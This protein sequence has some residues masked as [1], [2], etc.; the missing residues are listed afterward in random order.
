MYFCFTLRRRDSK[1]LPKNLFDAAK[2][3]RSESKARFNQALEWK[4]NL[5]AIAIIHIRAYILYVCARMLVLCTNVTCASRKL[6]NSCGNIFEKNATFWGENFV[7]SLMASIELW[8]I[9]PKCRAIFR[10][11]FEKFA[12]R[13]W[14]R[15]RI[16]GLEF[17]VFTRDLISKL[18][19]DPRNPAGRYCDSRI[20]R[21]LCRR[22]R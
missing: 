8:K 5:I 7:I 10:R 16:R 18:S 2:A 6:I 12:T 1:S 3:S 19:R 14:I 13:A 17:S 22:C 4:F 20:Q 11:R 21:S 9:E 15:A